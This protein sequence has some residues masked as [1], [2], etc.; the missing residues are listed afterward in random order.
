MGCDVCIVRL[1]D[2]ILLTPQPVSISFFY[3]ALCW[4]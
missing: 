2:Q 1:V 4:E 3:I